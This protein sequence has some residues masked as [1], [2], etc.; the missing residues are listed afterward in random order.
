MIN[1]NLGAGMRWKER[2]NWVAID[3]RYSGDTKNYLKFD[4][5]KDSLLTQFEE[6]SVDLIFTSHTLEHFTFDENCKI[7]K[8]CYLL[9]KSGG[10]LRIVVPDLELICKKYLDK[11]PEWWKANQIGPAP[12]SNFQLSFRFLGIIGSNRDYKFFTDRDNEAIIKGAHYF[13][14]DTYLLEEILTRAGFSNI[15]RCEYR[16][17]KFEGFEGLDERPICSLYM[18]AVK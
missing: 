9:L 13:A 5:L 2:E 6:N 15:Y 1:L 4:L 8:D 10:G 14:F 18:E 17:T 11:D 12:K 7:L 3:K 16:E